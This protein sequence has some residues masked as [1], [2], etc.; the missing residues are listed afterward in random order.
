MTAKAA[1]RAEVVA[2]AA[3][4]G[5]VDW[6]AIDWR[7]I[8]Q[9]VRRLQVRIA[10]AT[11]E[12]RWN[13]ARAPQRLLTHSFSG[14]ALAVRRVTENQGKRTP[15][16][17]GA[18]WT[19]PATKATAVG[20]LR[21]R[22]YRP[23]PLRRVYIPKSS[24]KMRPLGIPTMKDRAMQALY[25]LALDPVAETT[26][27]PNSYG[28]RQE[29]STADAI[30]Q[31]F[32]ALSKRD[33][34]Q[35][36]L[37]GDITSCFDRISHDW[38]LANVPMDKAILRKWLKAGF[39]ERGV[40]NATEAGTPQGGIIS[41]VL[42]NLALDGLERLLRRHYPPGSREGKHAKLNLVRYADDFVITGT[43]REV[44]EQEIRPLVE[45]FLRERGLELSPEKTTVTHIED[46]FDFLGQNVRKYR[47]I[48]LITPSK[49][50]TQA[51]LRKVRGIIKANKQ[52]PAG[53]VIAQLNPVIRGWANYHRHV[54]SSDAFSS[55]DHAIFRALW[56]WA[57]RRHPQKGARWCR[58]R[59]FRTI[60]GRQ[61]I[62]AGEVAGP[63]GQP[64]QI[65]LFRAESVRITRHAKIHREAN[66]YD[67]AWETYFEERLGVKMAAT[68]RGRREL[69]YLWKR[70]HGICPRCGQ[71]ITSITGWHNHHRVWR[72]KGGSDRADNRELLHPTCHTQVHHPQRSGAQPRPGNRAFRKA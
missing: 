22:G 13:K 58:K 44:L 8:N 32:N 43:S 36:I 3:S 26:G 48:L 51:F 50:N 38:L 37:E 39:M 49:K 42:A 29:R 54:V 68:L 41:P 46:G 67:P 57:R 24:G 31:C 7:R 1:A 10:K 71:P 60:K 28:F 30:G 55:V 18:T 59:Y 66:P 52:T 17:D 65:Q 53:K 27:D 62:F 64:R 63:G 69:L 33:R 72:S 5:E 6:H 70:Q 40:L 14:K 19:T 2:G 25:L 21:R 61:W 15:G 12:G 56:R 47:G 16:V 45:A 35:W 23:R 9:N 20:A 34:A 11:Q 4:H